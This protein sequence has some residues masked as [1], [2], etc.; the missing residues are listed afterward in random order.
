ML[1]AGLIIR[2]AEPRDA[3]ALAALGARTFADTFGADNSPEDL[4]AYLAG[5]YQAVV[6]LG[7]A[8]ENAENALRLPETQRNQARVRLP[9]RLRDLRASEPGSCHGRA[10]RSSPIPAS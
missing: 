3:G 7:T 5:A 1:T 9:L 6:K 8:C 4:R 2:R 10:A